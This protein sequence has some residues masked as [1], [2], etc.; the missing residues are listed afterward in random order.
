MT[1]KTLNVVNKTSV[2]KKTEAAKD[3]AKKGINCFLQGKQMQSGGVQVVSHAILQLKSVDAFASIKDYQKIVWPTLHISSDAMKIA[4]PQV[5]EYLLGVKA[6]KPSIIN[7]V[8]K[9]NI[10]VRTN[11]EK[12]IRQ[13]LK[14]VAILVANE[15]PVTAFVLNVNK[16]GASH[17]NLPVGLFNDEKNK[18]SFIGKVTQLDLDG[19]TLTLNRDSDGAQKVVKRSISYLL[20]IHAPRKQTT[21]T[22]EAI[23]LDEL[24]KITPPVGQLAILS[25]EMLTE[26]EHLVAWIDLEEEEQQAFDTLLANINAMKEIFGNYTAE[27]IADLR[28][29]S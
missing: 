13:A 6:A 8:Q 16:I 25:N 28:K 17:W 12:I 23:S 11:K 29:A 1:S 5:I 2:A 22:P 3:L 18:L 4:A 15:V 9:E 26:G 10:A 19:K 20:K 14:L 21:S 7:D 24:R 27:E